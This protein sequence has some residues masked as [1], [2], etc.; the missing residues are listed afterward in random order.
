MGKGA[1]MKKIIG[2]DLEPTLKRILELADTKGIND[3]ELAKFLGLSVENKT[4]SAWKRGY[5]KTY[6]QMLPQFSKIL[7]VSTDYLL[8]LT[9]NPK[10][11]YE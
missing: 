8:G 11:H 2:K 9:D 10:P 4:I 7:G 3:V 1:L 6:F 5:S